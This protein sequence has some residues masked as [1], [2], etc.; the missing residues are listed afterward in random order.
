MVVLSTIE[1]YPNLPRPILPFEINAGD[2][3]GFASAR[4]LLHPLLLASPLALLSFV[5]RGHEGAQF[6]QR[7][8]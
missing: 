7:R 6:E 5:P 8:S 4:V 1:P 2:N 3:D